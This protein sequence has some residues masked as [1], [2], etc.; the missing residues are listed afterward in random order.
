M[1]PLPLLNGWMVTRRSCA[2][3]ADS[4]VGVSGREVALPN[5]RPKSPIR[6]G[7]SAG[8]G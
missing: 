6:G 2:A 4:G 1:R 3:K 8:E 5:Q 7:I